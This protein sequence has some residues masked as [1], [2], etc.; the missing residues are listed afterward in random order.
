MDSLVFS[1]IPKTTV[2]KQVKIPISG[3]E[4][5]QP[6]TWY[7][8]PTGKRAIIK[9]RL[10]CTNRGAAAIATVTIAGTIMFEW[11]TSDTPV[12]GETYLDTPRG[13]SA[14]NGGQFALFDVELAAGET[15]VTSQNVGTNA[16]FNL[17]MEVLELPV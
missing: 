13:L 15:I 3:R 12:A 10:Q 11:N 6:F 4:V 9:G 8:C 7:T 5:L 14:L 2:Q 17:W 16:E 1:I